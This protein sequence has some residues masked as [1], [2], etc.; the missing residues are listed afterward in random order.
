LF[1]CG[2]SK[3]IKLRSYLA[4]SAFLPTPQDEFSRG[5]YSYFGLGST[6]RDVASLS[7]RV[8]SPAG[9]RV[10]FAGEHTNE[11]YQGSVHGAI[12]SGEETAEEAWGIITGTDEGGD[13][14][15][16][17]DMNINE[18]D[19]DDCGDCEDEDEL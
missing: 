10:L 17:D 5:A 13:E 8:G 12:I 18:G 11:E 3:G 6:G 2:F 7:R 1:L 19:I 4:Y 15:G 14:G 9:A 16:V